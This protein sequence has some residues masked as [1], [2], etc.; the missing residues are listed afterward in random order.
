MSFIFA[1]N[2]GA[3]DNVG[4]GGDSGSISLLNQWGL[5]MLCYRYVYVTVPVR[6]PPEGPRHVTVFAVTMVTRKQS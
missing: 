3:G 4:L 6:N 5:S 2:E 1:L